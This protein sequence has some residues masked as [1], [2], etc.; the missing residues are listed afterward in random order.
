M[1]S[2]VENTSQLG[3]LFPFGTTLMEPIL[4]DAGE[5]LVTYLGI[6]AAHRSPYD[7]LYKD[8]IVTIIMTKNC[9]YESLRKWLSQQHMDPQGLAYPTL[10]NKLVEMI[11]SGNFDPDLYKSKSKQNN[12]TNNKN[13]NKDDKEEETVGAIVEP[14]ELFADAPPIDPSPTEQDSDSDATSEG[15]NSSEIDDEETD[16]RRVF[17]LVNSGHYEDDNLTMMKQ[18]MILKALV[19]WLQSQHMKM[20]VMLMRI[21]LIQSLMT[22]VPCGPVVV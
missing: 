2:F 9:G 7:T 8:Q 1:E 4:T 16:I 17:A 12:H 11:N 15:D 20:I 6:D 5:T 10:S 3:G 19:V 21:T 13:K 22:T 14:T 18:S